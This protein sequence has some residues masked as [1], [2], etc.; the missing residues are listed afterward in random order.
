MDNNE[1]CYV[2]EDWFQLNHRNE[3]AEFREG[4]NGYNQVPSLQINPYNKDT[5][6]E[7]YHQFNRGYSYASFHATMY[8]L[9]NLD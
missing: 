4:Q 2:V 8:D 7:K 5:E 6:P 9:R 3:S 1:I